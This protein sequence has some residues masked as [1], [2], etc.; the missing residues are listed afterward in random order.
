MK[1]FDEE[2][3]PARSVA[4]ERPNFGERSVVE[5][6]AF[7][8]ALA[9]AAAGPKAFRLRFHRVLVFRLS[10]AK[11]LAVRSGLRVGVDR[12]GPSLRFWM[13]NTIVSP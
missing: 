1:E 13:T 12:Y 11:A 8:A 6:A 3:A 10:K 7:R 2:I 5:G 4:K 9:P